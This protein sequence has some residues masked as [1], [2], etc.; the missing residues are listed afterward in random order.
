MDLEHIVAM[1]TK[2]ADAQMDYADATLEWLAMRSR[3][4]RV[5]T[6]EGDFAG[7]R[8]WNNLRFQIDA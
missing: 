3:Q 5:F 4:R 2:C 7:Y 8:L 6:F 1:M